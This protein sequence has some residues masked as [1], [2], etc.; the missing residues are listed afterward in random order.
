MTWIYDLSTCDVKSL[1]TIALKELCKVGIGVHL[2]V[3]NVRTVWVSD[4]IK[5]L[6]IEILCW[7]Q[8]G[9]LSLLRSQY[10]F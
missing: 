6:T 4:L 2:Q 5:S 10:H 3:L 1:E 7:Y 8:D 9:S